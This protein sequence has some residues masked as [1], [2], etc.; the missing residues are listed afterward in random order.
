M[1][2]CE[3]GGCVQLAH[4]REKAAGVNGNK[5]WC[6]ACRVKAG[7]SAGDCVQLRELPAV[8]AP[9]PAKPFKVQVPEPLRIWP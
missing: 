3:G 5:A 8:V 7:V 9:A 6:E 4:W 2:Y 1:R